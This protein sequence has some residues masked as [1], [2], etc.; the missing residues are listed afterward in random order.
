MG[1]NC[2]AQTGAARLGAIGL[3]ATG[4]VKVFGPA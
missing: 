2:G 4:T 1:E 3:G